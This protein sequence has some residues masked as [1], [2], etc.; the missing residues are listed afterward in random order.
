MASA[1]KYRYQSTHMLVT[2]A[3]MV[4][5][6]M[7]GVEYVPPTGGL[8]KEGPCGEREVQ[9][10]GSEYFEQILQSVSKPLVATLKEIREYREYGH[11]T[12]KQYLLYQ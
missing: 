3:H 7:T 1:Q 8:G 12:K 11:S 10:R 6:D 2:R 4:K 9:W 5:H